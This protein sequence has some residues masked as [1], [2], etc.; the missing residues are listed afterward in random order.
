MSNVLT[1]EAAAALRES[2]CFGLRTTVEKEYARGLIAG[3]EAVMKLVE[4]T[5]MTTDDAIALVKTWQNKP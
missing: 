4:F 5:G 1:K 3:D 2:I